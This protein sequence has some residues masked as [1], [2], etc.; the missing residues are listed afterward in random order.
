MR[1]CEEVGKLIA[2]GVFRR[3][4]CLEGRVCLEDTK[5]LFIAIHNIALNFRGS[6]F[7]RIPVFKH[8]GEITLQ[9]CCL[10]YE[11]APNLIY[12]GYDIQA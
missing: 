11:H 3:E 12:Y 8:F 10:N 7:S 9:I 4:G 5:S 2:G 1:E 6:K